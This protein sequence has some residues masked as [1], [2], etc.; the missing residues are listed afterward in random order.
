MAA[1]TGSDSASAEHDDYRFKWPWMFSTTV[2]VTGYPY[3]AHHDCV[4]GSCTN[5]FDFVINDDIVRSATQARLWSA[6]VALPVVP[7]LETAT[8]SPWRRQ[9]RLTSYTLTWKTG[10]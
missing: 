7:E 5:A 3:T 10:A 2:S 4:N 9:G 6:S 1:L 8:L